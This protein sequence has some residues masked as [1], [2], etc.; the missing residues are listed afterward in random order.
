M[1][2]DIVIS[3]ENVSKAYRIW[4][5]PAA[6]LISPFQESLVKLL[7]ENSALARYLSRLATSH[8][9]DFHALRDISFTVQRGESVGIIGRNGSGKSTLLQ[10]IAGILQPTEGRVRVA[11]RV[12]ALLELGAGF[13]SDFTG[14]ENIFL[15]GA[16]LGLS[17]LEIE[18]R[19]D[20][21]AAYADIG[22]FIEQ[23]IKTYSTGMAMR[24]AFAVAAHVDADILIIDEALGVGDARF[25]LK[26]AKTIDDF[27]AA[28]KTMLF[29]SHDYSSLKRLCQR[30]ILLE[31][32]ELLLDNSPNPV[33]NFYT[34]LLAD[35]RSLD[36]LKAEA[37][38]SLE[39]DQNDPSIADMA[40]A[41]PMPEPAVVPVND[42]NFLVRKLNEARQVIARFAAE[43]P[44]R[45]RFSLLDVGETLE[46]ANARE[47]EFAYGGQ[48]GQIADLRVLDDS[49]KPALVFT[50]GDRMRL[51]FEARAFREI[52]EPI[53]AVTV[54]SAKGQDLYCTNT[55][56]V[57]LPTPRIA[58]RERHSVEFDLTL[59]LMPGEYFLSFGWVTFAGDKL[60]VI[61]R[62][63]DAT[64]FTVLPVD[65]RIGVANLHSQIRVRPLPAQSGPLA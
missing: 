29:V 13:N 12:A 27:I 54:K 47:N 23:P 17:R 4:E 1:S 50:T 25:Q 20:R 58:P 24:L 44:L 55:L 62:R 45:Q 6:R 65:R 53:Y 64:K 63:Y 31:R 39:R 33:V 37:R 2:E 56:Y 51:S 42:P 30:A 5:A 59:N 46:P 11:G 8:Y 7:P 35:P 22:D 36:A 16:V 26:C 38:A 10:I 21:I 49:G 48:S 61:H 41:Q 18:S 34:K 19:F 52:P 60:E 15:N 32:G 57:G 43:A 9:K 40:A 14:R 3:V 28:G